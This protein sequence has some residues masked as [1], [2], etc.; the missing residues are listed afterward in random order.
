MICPA[1]RHDNIQGEDLCAECGMDLAGLDVQ[2]WGVS[3]DDPLLARTLGELPLKKPLLLPLE[4]TVAEAVKLMQDRHEGCVFVLAK[5]RR[6]AGVF[7]ERDV[8]LRVVSRGRDPQAVPLAEVMTRDP[9]SLQKDDSLAF[10]LHRM[11]VDG[12]R[13]IPVLV[14]GRVMG[15]LS[16]RTVLRVLAEEALQ[17]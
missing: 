12:F 7:T 2:A 1:C 8:A 4:S 13:H 11:G 6:L 16:I 17:A 15:F 10:A 9:F 3:P 14:K 5:G